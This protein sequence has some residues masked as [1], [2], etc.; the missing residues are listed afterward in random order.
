M[1]QGLGGLRLPA[2]RHD[3][4]AGKLSTLPMPG[5]FDRI[6]RLFLGEN[7]QQ[8]RVVGDVEDSM[9]FRFS[10]IA[11]D[12]QYAAAGFGECQGEVRYNRG[13]AFTRAGT[14]NDQHIASAF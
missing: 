13:L 5:N 8:T 2:A 3:A 6:E 9:Q 12:E 10:S 14:G 4:Y 1:Q 11:V 7:F